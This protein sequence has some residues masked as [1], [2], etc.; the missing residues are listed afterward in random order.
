MISLFTKMETTNLNS[1]TDSKEAMLME[2]TDTIDKFNKTIYNPKL[3]NTI[4][5]IN[6]NDIDLNTRRLMDELENTKDDDFFKNEFSLLEVVQK[7]ETQLNRIKEDRDKDIYNKKNE[8]AS[9]EDVSRLRRKLNDEKLNRE[10]IENSL[11]YIKQLNKDLESKF[12][13][14]EDENK[15]LKK[16]LKIVNTQYNII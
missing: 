2:L 6:L 8:G 5:E 10:E 1:I 14:L 13:L 7:L 4:F 15:N 9:D 3:M 12:H 16:E 11:K